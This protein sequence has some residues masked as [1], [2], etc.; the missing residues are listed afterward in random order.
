MFAHARDIPAPLLQWAQLPRG[1][2]LSDPASGLPGPFPHATADAAADP[3]REGDLGGEPG[4]RGPGV[5][6]LWDHL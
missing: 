6:R 3:G 5:V 1:G 4:A 2:Q